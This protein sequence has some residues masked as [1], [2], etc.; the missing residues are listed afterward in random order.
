MQPW[1]DSIDISFDLGLKLPRAS[2]TNGFPQCYD[3]VPWN[4]EFDENFVSDEAQDYQ[5]REH[6]P[7]NKRHYTQ[8]EIFRG[9]AI[10]YIRKESGL[11]LN[12]PSISSQREYK[13]AG[14]QFASGVSSSYFNKSLPRSFY[15]SSND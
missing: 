6:S 11:I 13:I 2:S 7:S 1:R 9:Y 12:Q 3:E 5:V 10:L 4:T 15:Q 8:D 14:M